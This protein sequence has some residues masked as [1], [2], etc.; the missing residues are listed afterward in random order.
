M[1]S[2]NKPT[3][4]AEKARKLFSSA[5]ISNNNFIIIHPDYLCYLYQIGAALAYKNVYNVINLQV[6]STLQSAYAPFIFNKTSVI[7]WWKS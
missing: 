1:S 7:I 4:Q 5:I 3:R 2:Y 6:N